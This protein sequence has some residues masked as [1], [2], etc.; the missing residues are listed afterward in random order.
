L[1]GNCFE[2]WALKI[3]PEDFMIE[4]SKEGYKSL[5][6]HFGTLKFGE[7]EVTEQRIEPVANCDRF[8]G[9]VISGTMPSRKM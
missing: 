7:N 9:I 8:S 2:V 5:R 1:Q 4:L 3:F 6:R